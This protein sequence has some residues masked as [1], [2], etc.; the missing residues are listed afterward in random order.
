[1]GVF[2][3]SPLTKIMSLQKITFYWNFLLRVFVIVNSLS[4]KN[5]FC[6][7]KYLFCPA[8]TAERGRGTH[9]MGTCSVRPECGSIRQVACLFKKSKQTPFKFPASCKGCH[10][11]MCSM[12]TFTSTPVTEVFLRVALT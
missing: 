5:R 4:T 10:F 8:W 11:T 3:W 6:N 7:L 2:T 9:C 1:M 12:S